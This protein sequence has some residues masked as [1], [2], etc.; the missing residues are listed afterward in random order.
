MGIAGPQSMI[1]K[2]LADRGVRTV[3]SG[4]D[5]SIVP[6]EDAQFGDEGIDDVRS[7]NMQEQKQPLDP[8]QETGAEDSPATEIETSPRHRHGR[9]SDV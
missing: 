3:E 1:R 2:A 4:V 5:P 8:P 9:A 7:D 6:I